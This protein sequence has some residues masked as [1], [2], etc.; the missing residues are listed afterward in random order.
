[1][2]IKLDILQ[3][4][5]VILGVLMWIYIILVGGIPHPAVPKDFVPSWRQSLG[6]KI[7]PWVLYGIDY[8]IRGYKKKHGFAKWSD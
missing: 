6:S 3:T 2:R 7:M 5:H 1:M 4:Q 8:P